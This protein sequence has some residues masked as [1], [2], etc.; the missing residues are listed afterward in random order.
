VR[1]DLADRRTRRRWPRWRGGHD[2]HASEVSTS[3]SAHSSFFPRW[4]AGW[5]QRSELGGLCHRGIS[6]LLPAKPPGE[7]GQHE[8]GQRSARTWGIGK[9]EPIALTAIYDDMASR[10][11]GGGQKKNTQTKK[12]KKKQPKKKKNTQKNPPKKKKKHP[13]P[14]KKK[15]KKKTPPKKKK[16]KPPK[17][18]QQKKKMANTS[19]WSKAE[20]A[21]MVRGLQEHGRGECIVYA[22]TGAGHGRSSRAIRWCRS[23]R[24]RG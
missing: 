5:E 8:L 11:R 9:K 13:P 18:K 7:R 14:T 24:D 21:L 17:N 16:P 1:V 3:R 20:R 10:Q 6:S 22:T 4:A 15:K 23:G 12:K 19:G 2:R